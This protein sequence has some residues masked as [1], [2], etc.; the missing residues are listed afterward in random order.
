MKTIDVIIFYDVNSEMYTASPKHGKG[1]AIV[2]AKDL[3]EVKSVFEEAMK[4]SDAVRT[5]LRFS[6]SGEYRKT[7]EVTYNYEICDI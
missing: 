6:E 2:S 4:L 1:G 7:E 3:N 5:L